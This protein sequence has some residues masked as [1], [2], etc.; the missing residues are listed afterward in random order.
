MWDE[1]WT[2]RTK[3]EVLQSWVGKGKDGIA[4]LGRGKRGGRYPPEKMTRT[5]TR[6]CTY[7]PPAAISCGADAALVLNT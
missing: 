1:V 6:T 2:V 7:E 4:I 3:W 5:Y